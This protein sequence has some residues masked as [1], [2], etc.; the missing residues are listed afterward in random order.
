MKNFL[1]VLKEIFEYIWETKK[2]WL[3]P[4][5]CLLVILSLLIVTSSTVPVPVFVYPLV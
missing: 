1:K 4:L 5:V 2:W 3:V